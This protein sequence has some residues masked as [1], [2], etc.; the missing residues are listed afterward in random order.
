M[1]PLALFAGTLALVTALA[2]CNRGAKPPVGLTG[3]LADSAEQVLFGVRYLLTNEG[4]K[5]G[6]LF[7][8]TAFVFD[9][10]TRFVFGNVRATFNNEMGVKDGTLRG[11]RGSY[12]FRSQVLE[13]WG[14][15]VITTEDGRRLESPHIVFRQLANEVSSDTS[16][17]MTD[18]S[19]SVTR[20]IGFRADPGLNRIRILRAAGGSGVITLPSQ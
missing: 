12:S 6:E 19:G 18:A 20:G 17:T 4:V 13:G 9:D 7:A 11:D 3:G 5:R 1:K 10:Q 16:F 8:D 2:G 15:V 14:N